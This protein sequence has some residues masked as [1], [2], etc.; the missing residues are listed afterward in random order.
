M[1][2]NIHPSDLR[3]AIKRYEGGGRVISPDVSQELEVFQNELKRNDIS[4]VDRAFFE[5]AVEN[6][7]KNYITTLD[8]EEIGVLISSIQDL[9]EG[10]W[11]KKN[12]QKLLGTSK[13]EKSRYGNDITIQVGD[14]SVLDSIEAETDFGKFIQNRSIGT[15][16]IKD[17]I[18]LEIL[19]PDVESFINQIV[20]KSTVEI[21]K[22]ASLKRKKEIE[23]EQ[24]VEN[25]LPLQ[26]YKD[27]YKKLNSSI[28][29]EE[30]K[31][32]LWYKDSI[33][34]KLSNDWYEIA[35]EEPD[36]RTDEQKK[37]DWVSNGL[38]FYFQGIFLPL[39]LYASGNIY[40]KISRIVNA[41]ENSGQDIDFIV[42][43]FGERVL[44]LHLD[45]LNHAFESIFANRLVL[46]ANENENNLILKPISHFA[47][48]FKI[49]QT[50]TFDEFKWWIDMS[51]QIRLDKTS[52]D[53]WKKK[54]I[55][56]L[57]LT[58]AFC[59]WMLS[60]KGNLD[61]R[62]G[63]TGNDIIYFYIEKR[64][65]QAPSSMSD[66]EKEAFRAQIARMKSKAASEGN[67]LF[68]EFLRTELDINQ[69]TTIENKWNSKFNNYLKP[70][71][72]KIP[73][74][75]NITNRFFDEEPFEVKEEK[76]EAVSF[77]FNEGSGCLA[78][79]VGVGK[80]LSAI[81][82]IEQ[83]IVAGYCKRPFLVVPN[84]TYKQ[85]LSEIK[86]AL[87]NRKV[88]GLFNLGV[89]YSQK[90]LDENNEVKMVDENSISVLTYE[91][92]SK[93]G[94]NEETQSK[95][96]ENLYDILNQGDEESNQSKKKEASFYEKL[97]GLIGKGLKGTNIEIEALGF[98]F[99]CYD[100]A[101]ALKKIFTSVKGE[102]EEGEKK[103]RKSY[104][105]QAGTPSNTALKGFMI[106]N[107]ILRNNNDRNVLLLTATPFT[108]SPLEVFS[109]LSLVAH[110]HLE[111]LGIVNINDFFDNYID[112]Q[113]DLTINHKLQPQYK[114]IVKG[115]NNLPSLQKIIFRFFN[116]KDGDDV[117]VVRPNKIVIPLVK[118]LVNNEIMTLPPEEQVTSSLEMTP[119]QKQYMA[120]V[121]AYAE[122]ISELEYENADIEDIDD[123]DDH[124][125][126]ET[127]SNSALNQNEKSGVRALRSMNFSRNIALSPYLYEFN[128]LGAPT[129][130]EYVNSS[131]KLKY[132]ME[133][134]RS[135]K[136][137][138]IEHNEPISGQVIYM[139]RGLRYFNLLKDYLIHEIG[140]KPHEVGEITAKM[141]TDKKRATQDAFLGRHYNEKLQDYEPLSDEQ[142]IKVLLG[143]SSIKEGINLQTKSTVLYNCFLDWNPTDIIQLEGRIWRQKNEF[144][145][146]RIVNPLVIDSIDIFM[147]QKLE[148][149]TA[150]I[151][152]I[153]STNNKSVFK[154]EEIDPEEIKFA[155]IKDPMVIAKLES[156][157]KTVKLQDEIRSLQS[158]KDR[159]KDYLSAKESYFQLESEINTLISEIS[160]KNSSKNLDAKINF[161]FNF[162]KQEYPKD[163]NGKIM[164]S[165][166][167][168]QYNYA[169]LIERFGELSPIDKP[170]EPYWTTRLKTYKKLI[171][172]ENKYLFEPRNLTG[173]DAKEFKAKTEQEIDNLKTQLAFLESAKYV[174][175][176]TKEIIADREKNKFEIKPIDKLVREFSSLNTLLSIKRIKGAPKPKMNIDIIHNK[177]Q[178]ALDLLK[179]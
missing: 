150:R 94:F 131:S 87:P 143:S 92:F 50:I 162:F 130:K 44:Q 31:A 173:E 5:K 29:I 154:L 76:R 134:I 23:G 14:I 67:R 98:D 171:E 17:D 71:Y 6:I 164:A 33:G 21:G 49:T 106:S 74:A 89:E 1:M 90:V 178:K 26:S 39:P 41:G 78:Y 111:K 103:A 85:W 118:K 25:K 135:V 11:Y 101:H 105:I 58:E 147:F 75:F 82:I 153:W 8:M 95:L 115:F 157:T 123:E 117:G 59:L 149:K 20:E 65:R 124:E 37:L 108:N 7:K 113:T 139:D 28:S 126:V 10:N 165:H 148:E 156:E 86:N 38:L 133:C 136:D 24:E 104:N 140:F 88:N 114:P 53:D 69:K 119:I 132:V 45:T 52:G 158:L 167:D 168:K 43:N 2:D 99:V 102:V 146:V 93:L 48:E 62:G 128:G 110:H 63:I 73:V 174:E 144:M 160:P 57:S 27:I 177:L 129:Y 19:K 137:Y 175:N 163:D 127:L 159:L 172:K 122:G 81:M 155:L 97:E 151:N 72:K 61:V 46:T 176:R 125:G 179:N 96:M 16:H 121:I 18:S 68:L 107:Y 42:S 138:H 79:D 47:K 77:I 12:P 34:Q 91:G 51:G 4:D 3:S 142:R 109:M 66:E 36:Q 64:T 22:K 120:D 152:T 13:L 116:Y 84:Q 141:T 112:V 145:N 55:P 54:T 9:R 15:T 32:Y 40:E 30:L 56:E 170:S 169:D 60:Q 161:M 80:S 83:F 70:D 35:Y 166:F 100:E